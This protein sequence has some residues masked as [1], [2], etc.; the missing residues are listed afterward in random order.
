[1]C[2]FTFSMFYGDTLRVLSSQ[3]WVPLQRNPLPGC[4]S[5]CCLQLSKGAESKPFISSPCLSV[6]IPDAH[7]P[8]SAMSLKYTVVN[9]CPV[10]NLEIRKQAIHTCTTQ[11][12]PPLIFSC[13]SQLVFLYLCAHLSTCLGLYWG[14]S[15]SPVLIEHDGLTS[16]PCQVQF[17]LTSALKTVQTVV[18]TV[19]HLTRCTGA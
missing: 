11:R 1:M 17:F 12:W 10:A 3:K 8:A 6:R 15:G 18:S 13:I 7:K 16:P 5:V 14:Q 9:E 19:S 2:W 4:S